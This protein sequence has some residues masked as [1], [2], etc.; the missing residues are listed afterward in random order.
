MG[1]LYDGIMGLAVADALGVPFEFKA[2]DTF[3]V[4]GMVGYGTHRQP[5]GT[6]S[7]DTSMTLATLASL[8]EKGKIDLKDMMERFCAWI[9]EGAYTAHGEV[10]DFGGTTIRA[11]EAYKKHGNVRK[12]GGTSTHSNG[13]GSLMRILPLAFVPHTSLDICDVSAL[14][15]AHGISVLSCRYY[16][17][18][19]KKLLEGA[20]KREAVKSLDYDCEGEFIRVPIIDCYKREQIKSTG[21]VLDTLEAA[22]WCLLTTENYRDCV[23]TAV[24]LGDDTDT[25]AAVAGGL[26]GIYYGSGGENGIPEEW[27]AA[28]AKKEYI[29]ELCEKAENKLG[30][31]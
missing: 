12:C 9:Y 20:D 8:A 13:N 30:T 10:F 25:V 17:K 6:W 18:V 26:A 21:Y 31:K 15:H 29:A 19:A 4:T 3:R 28:L 7:D 16:L 24:E 2:R 5:A 23:I 22:L 1:K 14:T 27:I 11:I